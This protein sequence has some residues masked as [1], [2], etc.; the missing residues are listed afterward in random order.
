[1][2]LYMNISICIIYRAFNPATPHTYEF[3]FRLRYF[4]FTY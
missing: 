4:T 3:L 1:M 2:I